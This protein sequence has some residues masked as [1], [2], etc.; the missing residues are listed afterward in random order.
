MAY[1]FFHSILLAKLSH[2]SLRFKVWIN[3]LNL[4]VEAAASSHYKGLLYR[5]GERIGSILNCRIVTY[6]G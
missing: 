4:L 5:W 1:H 2:K 6:A 3:R